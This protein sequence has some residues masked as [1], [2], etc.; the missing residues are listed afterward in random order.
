M[1]VLRTYP[2]PEFPSCERIRR[3]RSCGTTVA[4]GEAVLRVIKSGDIADIFRTVKDAAA[5]LDAGSRAEL[6]E[7]LQNL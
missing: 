4:T 7:L 3:C 2:D 1:R 5:T 6:R